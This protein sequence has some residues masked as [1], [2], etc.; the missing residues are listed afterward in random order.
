MTSRRSKRIFAVISAVLVAFTL[1]VPTAGVQTAYA[2]GSPQE[3]IPGGMAFGVKF[4]TEG[5][6]V[7]GT[8]GVETA[9]GVVSPAKD[10]GL[11]AGDVIIRAGGKEFKSASELIEVIEGSGGKSVYLAYL[12]NG[13]ES[14]VEV[15]P[16]RDLENG[17]YRIGVMVRDSTAG[18]GTV[19]FID[20]ETLDFG[21]LGHG[22]Y[23]SETGMLLPLARGAVVDVDI[24]DVVKS[25]RN[26]PGELRGDFNTKV[27][28]EL[29]SNSD[30]GVF[31]RFASLPKGVHEAIPIASRGEI[32]E[33]KAFILTTLS[34]NKVGEYEIEIEHVYKNSG[35]TKNF[36]IR[37]TDPKLLEQTGGIVQGMSGSPII[38]NG[39][40]IGA[41]THV[42]VN[43]PERGYG[44]CIENMLSAAFDV[45]KTEQENPMAA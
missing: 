2:A 17:D 16:V 42:L 39:K 25:E 44:I 15:T 38:Q 20:P 36:L 1:I 10:C 9:S 19:S 41:V 22:I 12:R 8:T 4:F 21:G 23:D 29:W 14:T 5:A 45:G 6:I 43:D 30:Q 32:S 26:D 11:K 31:G 34:D 37:A 27:I 13:E 3:L 35:S 7:I 24:T 40:L 18:I 28:G 33:G